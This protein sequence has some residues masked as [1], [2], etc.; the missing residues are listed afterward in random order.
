MSSQVYRL[1]SAAG[2]RT[3]NQSAGGHHDQHKNIAPPG[4]V[5]SPRR[6]F[7]SETKAITSSLFAVSALT[8][9]ISIKIA[10]LTKR[11]ITYDH[12]VD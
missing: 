1:A 2:F 12:S 6:S 7:F 3:W 5:P 9:M 11:L 10:Q 4:H 8:R